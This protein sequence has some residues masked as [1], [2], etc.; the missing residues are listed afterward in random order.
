MILGHKG[1]CIP[2]STDTKVTYYGFMAMKLMIMKYYQTV[3]CSTD[4]IKLCIATLKK[5]YKITVSA[6]KNTNNFTEAFQNYLY[7]FF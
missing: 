4:Y 6:Q 5:K 3:Q 7:T 1:Q 2:R